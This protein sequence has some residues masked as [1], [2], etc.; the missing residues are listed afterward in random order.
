MNKQSAI[1]WL[2]KAYHNLSAAKLLFEANH[3]L[4]V[5]AV[6]LH[7]A[8]EKIL[9]SFLAYENKKIPKTHN[10]AQISVLIK[11]FIQFNV[12]ELEL[13]HTISKYHIESSYPMPNKILPEKNEINLVLGFSEELFKR[14]CKILD[15]DKKEV[16][17]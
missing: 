7:Y 13:L 8:I 5:V 9:K 10:L 14:V 6:E 11:K 1:E 16:K 12:D 3:Y 15:I 4:D 17:V 2:Q